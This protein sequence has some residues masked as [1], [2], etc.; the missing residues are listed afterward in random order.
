MENTIETIK[1]GHWYVDGFCNTNIITP[2]KDSAYQKGYRWQTVKSCINTEVAKIRCKHYN[3]H[4]EGI[5]IK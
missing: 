3:L 1:I 5:E 2:I 4:H